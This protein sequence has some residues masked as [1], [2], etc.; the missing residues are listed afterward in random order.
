[1]SL[2]SPITLS[3]RARAAAVSD[4][5]RSLPRLA[6]WLL[7]LLLSLQ[8]VRL[9]WMVVLTPAPIGALP[10]DA[11]PSLA[12]ATTRSTFDPFFPGIAGPSADANTAGLVL[13]GL[14]GDARGSAAI[15]ADADSAQQVYRVGDSV[16]PGVLL[17]AVAAD[18]VMLSAGGGQQ[19]LG[20]GDAAVPAVAGTLPR[21]L[22][23]AAVAPAD[24]TIDPARLLAQAG[25]QPLLEGDR[26][27]GY[28]LIPRGD[29]ALLRQAGLAAGDVLLAVNG[30]PLTPERYS[31]LAED[32]A[33][34]TA[35]TI[36]YR[37]GTET[38][39]TTVQAPAR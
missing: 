6:L 21:G 33:A 34:A 30:Q 39:T 3:R 9:T 5:H 31:T 20:F 36:A 18:H 16:R 22:P 4:W 15:L 25:L 19:R 37:R 29:G 28:T 26:V 2:P 27:T 8:A 38:L 13:F 23:A 14:R 11:T 17:V 10:V 7:A 35:I 1:M 32:L 12:A 24:L